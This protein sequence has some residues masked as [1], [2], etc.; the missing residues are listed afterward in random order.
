MGSLP[1]VP[2]RRSAWRPNSRT[3]V[4]RRRP[5]PRNTNGQFNA[6]LA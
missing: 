3:L 5:P 4:P 2:L 6:A 1:V